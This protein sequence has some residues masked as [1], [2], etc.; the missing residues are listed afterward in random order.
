[1]RIISYQIKSIR[2][3]IEI[4]QKNQIEIWELK[5]TIVEILEKSQ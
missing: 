3:V 1:M 2:K 5:S 4:I